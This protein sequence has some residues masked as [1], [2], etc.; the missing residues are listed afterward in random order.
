MTPEQLNWTDKQWASHLACDVQ[1]VPTLRK[2][3]SENYFP[4]V[5]KNKETGKY[6]F[7]MTK[8]DRTPSGAKRILPF[9]SY[10]KEF[11]TQDSAIKYANETIIPSLEFSHISAAR[12][13]V[14]VRA[15]Q[16]LHIN[17]KQK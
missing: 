8:M 2:R 17:E 1:D 14:P 12:I 6:A 15:L 16:M 5:C 11:A 4:G 3:I 9:L 13:G 10:G 7:F